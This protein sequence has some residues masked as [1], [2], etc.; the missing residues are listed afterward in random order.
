MKLATIL[1]DVLLYEGLI[2]THDIDTT[3]DQLKRW[4]VSNKKFNIEKTTRNTIQLKFGEKL[5]ESELDNLLKWINILGWYVS[6]YLV[7]DIPLKTKSFINTESLKKDIERHSLLLMS[8]EAK[9]DLEL[10]KYELN[11]LY[12]I[13]PSKNDKKIEKIGLVPRSLSRISYHPERIYITSNKNIAWG[14]ADLFAKR[15][16]KYTLYKIDIDGLRRYNNGI[17]FFKDPNLSGG[18]YT[19]SNIPTRFLTKIYTKTIYIQ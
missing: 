15:T 9:Y 3:S 13:T 14:L 2:Y 1:Q 6:E 18:L 5:N 7:N 4:V 11:D 8:L 19:L 12:H 10:N 16:E 17:R